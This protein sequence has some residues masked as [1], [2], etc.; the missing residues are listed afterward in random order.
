MRILIACEFSGV[1]REAFARRGHD[2]WSCDLLP[3]EIPGQHI[4]DDVLKHL[5]DGWDMMIAHPPCVYLT[6]RGRYRAAKQPCEVVISRVADARSAKGIY[7][8]HQAFFRCVNPFDK[9]YLRR[10]PNPLKLPTHNRLQMQR[11]Y[12]SVPAKG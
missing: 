9:P 11:S 7:L 3:T 10:N 1:V 2:A 8:D 5:D 6:A 12:L 4:Q